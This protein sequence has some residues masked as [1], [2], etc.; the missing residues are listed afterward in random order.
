MLFNEFKSVHG[1]ELT[2][3][4][5]AAARGSRERAP[6][7]DYIYEQPPDENCWR[8][9]AELRGDA[10]LPGAARI[11]GGGAGRAH[12][13]NGSGAVERRRSDRK[14]TLYMNRVRQASITGR[15]SK[16]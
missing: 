6:G 14:L 13:G 11:G 9:A 4:R 15:S 1:A 5:A 2:M 3:Q 10:D 16:W 8:A 7:S 12:D